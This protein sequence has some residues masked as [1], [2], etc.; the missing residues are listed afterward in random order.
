L[1]GIAF[2]IGTFRNFGIYHWAWQYASVKELISLVEAVGISSMLIAFSILIFGFVG[3]PFRVLVVDA[4]ICFAFLGGGRLF[5]RHWM[6]NMHKGN[7]MGKKRVIL[8][9]GAGD[10]GEMISRE[11]L[12]LPHLGYSPVGFVDDDNTKKGMYIHGLPILGE[13]NEIRTLVDKYSIDEI[14]I[15]I[16]SAAGKEIRRIVNYCEESKVLFRIVPG[17]YELI[18]GSIHISQI[19]NVQID[20]LLGREPVAIDLKEIAGYLTDAVILVTGA[21]GSIGSEICKQVALFQPKELLLFGRGENSIFNIE[22][23]LRKKYPFL[24]IK[25]VIG[26]MRDN[27]KVDYLFKKYHPTVVFHAA[28]HKHVSLMEANPDEAIL[29]NILGTQNLIR[30]ADH[31]G[32][33]IFVNISTDKAVNPTSVMGASKRIIEM[34][35]QAQ[36]QGGSETKFVSVRF[37]NVLDSR[38]SVVPIFKQQIL[39][40]GPVTITHPGVTRYFMTIPEAVQLVIQAGA[41]GKGGEIFILDMGEPVKILDL[42]KDLIK[43]SG[44]EVGQDIEIKI[45]G[46]RPGEKLFEEI[47]TSSEGTRATKHKKIFIA[48]PETR[49]YDKLK[50]EIDVLTDLAE[51]RQ[52]DQIRARILHLAS[53]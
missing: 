23:E 2:R 36:A 42:A 37:G 20:D 8:I 19:R 7:K 28:A 13:T 9:V 4:V 30:A 46:L 39:A 1:L 52:I 16:P 35:L 31:Y 43:L 50:A 18:D 41:M 48:K 45:I 12:K 10:A 21:G 33:K 14:V 3:F 5:I 11:M 34:I 17:V 27:L 32:V 22:W 38:G 40:G 24:N 51:K 25:V 15:A 29:N 44:L 53:S 49:N 26:D 47:F 6:Q